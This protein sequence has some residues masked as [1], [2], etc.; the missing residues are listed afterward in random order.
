VSFSNQVPFKPLLEYREVTSQRQ[1]QDNTAWKEQLFD[2]NFEAESFGMW[3]FQ[4]FGQCS[5]ICGGNR[6]GHG[7]IAL[8]HLETID[9]LYEWSYRLL[10]CCPQSLKNRF[11]KWT[12]L[13]AVRI[14]WTF[15]HETP[16]APFSEVFPE[17]RSRYP[18]IDELISFLR[19]PLA[20]QHWP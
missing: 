6:I 11:H 8:R 7:R 18:K 9:C 17:C 2:I 14:I 1:N 10:R 3:A 19:F 5:S 15:L 16:C 13:V 12:I 4:M 20:Q